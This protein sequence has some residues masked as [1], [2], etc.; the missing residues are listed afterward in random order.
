MKDE[1]FQEVLDRVEKDKSEATASQYLTKIEDFRGWLQESDDKP[2]F[3]DVDMFDVEDWLELLDERYNNASSVGKGSSALVAAFE[4][5]E[6]LGRTGR[7]EADVD[8]ELWARHGTPAEQADY[9]ADDTDSYKSKQSKENI[10]YL[11]PEQIN[12]M[13][14]EAERLRDNLII[15]TLFQ[16]GCRCSEFVEIRLEDIDLEERSI[17]IRGKG[18][19]NR[20]VYFQDNVKFLLDIWIDE[21]RPSI[22]HAEDSPYLTPTSHSEN[23]TTYTVEEV[24]R[25]CAEAANLQTVYGTSS[26]GVDLHSVTPHVLRHSFA[27]AAL[28]E[29][30]NVY[31]LSQALG[32]ANTEITTSTYLHEDDDEVRKAWRSRG[33]AAPDTSS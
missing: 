33:P 7:I 1:D 3:E 14:R 5:L 8:Y 24:V 15:R 29:G 4:Q 10:K 18:R 17:N 27:M 19:K 31:N 22:F 13:A 28:K 12:E 6:K 23:I 11:K 30:W 20:T 32:H 25:S 16:T 9:S 2:S 21:R 26:T